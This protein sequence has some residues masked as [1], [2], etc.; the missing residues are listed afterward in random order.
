MIDKT[1]DV[2]LVFIISFRNLTNY[3]KYESNII[4]TIFDKVN[5]IILESLLEI[6]RYFNINID[7][8]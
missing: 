1:P 7:Q 4:I 8:I 5:N 6:T 2:V 3:I